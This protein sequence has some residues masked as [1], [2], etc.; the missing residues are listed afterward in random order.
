MHS[1]SFASL[2]SPAN[3]LSS[4]ISGHNHGRTSFPNDET[5][6]LVSLDPETN[7][8][9]PRRQR[10]R[11]VRIQGRLAIVRTVSV[12]NLVQAKSWA[13]T[14]RTDVNRE[15]LRN[16]PIRRQGSYDGSE[17]EDEDKDD[18]D[19]D[20]VEGD[21]EF[22]GYGIGGA[23]NIRRPTDVMGAS[24]SASTSL[25]SLIHTP[26]H[27]PAITLKP[28]KPGKLRLRVAGLLHNLRGYKRSKCLAR[29]L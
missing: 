5:V 12:A 4:R 2:S 14:T 20:T 11:R 3:V 19:D 9:L 26:S 25:L 24:S 16:T 23:G 18:Y 7:K 1:L 21:A 13:S 27:S 15:H 10:P 8:L 17:I 28:T 6:P 29:D 22:R